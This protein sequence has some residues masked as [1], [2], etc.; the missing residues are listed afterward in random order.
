MLYYVVWFYSVSAYFLFNYRV[1]FQ[2]TNYPIDSA[3]TCIIILCMY[4]G[5]FCFIFTII[6][7]V[8]KNLQNV[9][10][11]YGAVS[12]LFLICYNMWSLNFYNRKI[13]VVV[14]DSIFKF[15]QYFNSSITFQM[16]LSSMK[17]EGIIICKNVFN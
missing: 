16:Y 7:Y 11:T 8:L 9:N 15:I 1:Y 4:I 12:Y 5:S 6:I 13:N 17:V 10:Y 2:N 3:P 14:N